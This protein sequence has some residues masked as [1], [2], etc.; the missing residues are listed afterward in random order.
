MRETP[1]QLD[2]HTVEVLR[3]GLRIVALRALGDADAAE[4]VAQE[5]LVRGLEALG[6]GRVQR[7]DNLG[8]YLRG[9]LR[10]VI[11]DTIRNRSQTVSLETLPEPTDKHPGSD[12]LATLI[13]REQQ[14][15]VA[16]L[17][18]ELSP[19]ARECLMLCIFHGLP[20][21][22]V[23]ARLGE[24]AA[25]IRKRRSRAIEKIRAI[26]KDGKRDEERHE[27]RKKG[28]TTADDR[29]TEGSADKEASDET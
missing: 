3:S 8:A 29:G 7:P 6:K 27:T 4:E 28:T 2:D 10:H 17:M 15:E 1:G 14:A 12:A 11:A 5:T 24:P 18:A 23:A 25:R 16:R 20:P 19:K 22:E 21:R 9:I 26:L 13:T